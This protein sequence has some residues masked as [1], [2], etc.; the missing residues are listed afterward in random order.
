MEILEEEVLSRCFEKGRSLVNVEDRERRD[1]E[2]GGEKVRE[3]GRDEV[4]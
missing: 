3:G 2:R 4:T 1:R